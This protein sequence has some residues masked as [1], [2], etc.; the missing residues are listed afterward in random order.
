VSEIAPPPPALPALL[1]M[2]ENPTVATNKPT[3]QPAMN[4]YM[5]RGWWVDISRFYP[6]EADS[7]KTF[8]YFL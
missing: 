6:G 1:S 2:N 3:A 8:T 5:D 4:E 7:F